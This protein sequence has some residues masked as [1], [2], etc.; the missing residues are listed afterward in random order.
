MNVMEVG[1]EMLAIRRHI[2]STT[3]TI[4]AYATTRSVS[5]IQVTVVHIVVRL[6]IARSTALLLTM[7][8]VRITE[9]VTAPRTTLG[10]IATT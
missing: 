8:F 5:A 4:E 1:R 3:A 7:E 6:S 10:M 2:V 9:N